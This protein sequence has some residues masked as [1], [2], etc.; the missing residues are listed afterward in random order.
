[1]Y[2]VRFM[3]N[4]LWDFFGT[5]INGTNVFK[6]HFAFVHCYILYQNIVEVQLDILTFFLRPC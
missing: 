2:F 5:F 3:L 1:M 4:I 6:F